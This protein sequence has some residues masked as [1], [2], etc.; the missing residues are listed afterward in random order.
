MASSGSWTARHLGCATDMSE[1]SESG[2]IMTGSIAIS[3]DMSWTAAGLVRELLRSGSETERA[4]LTRRV[5]S[6]GPR[7]VEVGR[8]FVAADWAVRRVAPVALEYAGLPQVA[9]TFRERNEVEP[10]EPLYGGENAF[11]MCSEAA[12]GVPVLRS[13]GTTVCSAQAARLAPTER[14]ARFA[15]IDTGLLAARCV[16]NISETFPAARDELF[17]AALLLLERLRE[18]AP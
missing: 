5:V 2:R 14:A 16:F 8:A 4:A 12:R 18:Y 9:A 11:W 6:C 17:N 10:H 3:D 1:E 13:V 7:A 15:A